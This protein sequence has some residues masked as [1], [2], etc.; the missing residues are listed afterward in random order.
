MGNC[1]VFV[2]TGELIAMDLSAH[3]LGR[4]VS[5]KGSAF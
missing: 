4:F 3:T 2:R 1:G 5:E